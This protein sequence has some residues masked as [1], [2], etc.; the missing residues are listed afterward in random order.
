MGGKRGLRIGSLVRPTRVAELVEQAAV[1]S[2]HR[3]F[4]ISSANLL[5]RPGAKTWVRIA[6]GFSRGG[7]ISAGGKPSGNRP[8]RHAKLLLTFLTTKHILKEALPYFKLDQAAVLSAPADTSP[9]IT[10]FGP[11]TAF[12]CDGLQRSLNRLKSIVRNSFRAFECG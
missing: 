4:D 8:L 10:G 12:K 9:V 3:M 2:R 7:R 1:N 5:A 11:I 6:T